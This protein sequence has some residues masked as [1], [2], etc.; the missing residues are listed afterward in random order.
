MVDFVEFDRAA[1]EDG[2]ASPTRACASRRRRAWGRAA[3]RRGRRPR[4][5]DDPRDRRPPR[6]GDDRDGL[7]RTHGPALD[8]AGKR[9]QRRRAP[10]RRP[11]LIIPPALA[12]ARARSLSPRREHVART[13]E[14]SNLGE[15][16]RA[17]LHPIAD[18]AAIGDGRPS[19]WSRATGR[20]TG[21]ACPTSIRPACSLPC[22]TL[23]AGD[24]SRWGPR[25][26]GRCKRRYLPD[27]NVLETTFTTAQGVVQVTDAL[28]L[29]GSTS[30]RR[31]S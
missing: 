8:A 28:T 11:T 12:D 16:L 31:A 22:S 29:P 5:E 13:A 17:R 2:A 10:R 14:R 24:A 30:D 7:A 20:S 9:L 15:P 25:S 26:R 27:T 19:R 4:L 23:I 18:Y 1:A 21:F 3:R 6:R